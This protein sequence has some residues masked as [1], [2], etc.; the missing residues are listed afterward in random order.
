[1]T[2]AGSTYPYKQDPNDSNLRIAPSLPSVEEL[3]KAMDVFTCCIKLA[4]AELNK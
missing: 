1:M 2:G 3:D 4:W